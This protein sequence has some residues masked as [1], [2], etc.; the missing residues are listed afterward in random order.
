MIIINTIDEKYF[1]LNGT[2]FAR[3]FHPLKLGNDKVALYN[4]FD[5]RLQILPGVHYS[6]V[7]VDA[8]AFDSQAA[9]IS[10]LLPVVYVSF[11]ESVNIDDYQLKNEKERRAVT[12]RCQVPEK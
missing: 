5:T 4:I 6:E 1:E 2:R 7:S 3:I 12:P 9:L 8:T 11:A 10:A